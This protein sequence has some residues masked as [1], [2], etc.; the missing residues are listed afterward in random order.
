MA[1]PVRF[2]RPFQIGH[3][4][5][6][7]FHLL[8]PAAD[9]K[10]V[11]HTLFLS[12]PFNGV[13]VTAQ[14]PVQLNGFCKYSFLQDPGGICGF[15]IIT[16]TANTRVRNVAVVVGSESENRKTLFHLQPQGVLIMESSDSNTL[17]VALG[18]ESSLLV[19]VDL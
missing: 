6:K 18:V 15:V 2:D 4:V 7:Q 19:K 12:K 16:P 14:E 13:E 5:E 17:F 9:N 11:L 1:S 8:G 3:Y 10:G